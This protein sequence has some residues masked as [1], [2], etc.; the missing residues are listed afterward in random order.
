MHNVAIIDDDLGDHPGD[1]A[2]IDIVDV[3]RH[4]HRRRYV[5]CGR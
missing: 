3:G 4:R 5:R 2:V 1:V